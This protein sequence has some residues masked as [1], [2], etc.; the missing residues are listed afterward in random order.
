MQR[1][2]CARKRCVHPRVYMRAKAKYS[3]RA[4]IWGMCTGALAHVQV[5]GACEGGLQKVCHSMRPRPCAPGFG[6]HHAMHMPRVCREWHA[7][8]EDSARWDGGDAKS[9]GDL[10][11]GTWNGARAGAG[12]HAQVVNKEQAARE[13]GTRAVCVLARGS[14]SKKASKLGRMRAL[15][16]R[17]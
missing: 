6:S 16:S 13:K 8:E 1:P 4:C 17:P 11:E 3:R 2:I 5:L 14:A 9:R 7:C 15:V 10:R 12:R